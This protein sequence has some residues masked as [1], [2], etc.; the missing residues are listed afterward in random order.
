MMTQTERAKRRGQ[1]KCKECRSACLRGGNSDHLIGR[2][3]KEVSNS[4]HLIGSRVNGLDWLPYRFSICNPRAVNTGSRTHISTEIL[5]GV[6]QV[7]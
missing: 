5:L 1:H 7:E 3:S 4:N 6:E 2:R